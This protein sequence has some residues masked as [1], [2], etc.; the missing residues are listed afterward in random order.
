MPV[1]VMLRAEGGNQT[2]V[3]FIEGKS[4]DFDFESNGQPVEV[5]V[6]PNNKILRMS[7]ELKIAIV[8]RK[9]IELFQEGE[10]AEAQQ[11][12]EAALKLDRSN[13]WVYYNLGLLFMAQHNWQLALRRHRM[14]Q[15]EPVHSSMM[16]ER[17]RGPD[18]HD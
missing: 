17:P 8:A 6:D 13:S 9:G 2:S 1:E 18:T 11:Q 5:V 14:Q 12:L 15:I 10:Y 3:I 7:D 4:E 16:K